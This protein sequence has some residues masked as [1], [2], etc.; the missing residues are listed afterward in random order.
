[1]NIAR[2]DYSAAT[3]GFLNRALANG[4]LTVGELEAKARAAGLLGERQSI[5]HVKAF[6]KA[7]KSLGI[8]SVRGGF[9]RGGQ[10]V[11]IMDQLPTPR[12]PRGAGRP[13]SGPAAIDHAEVEDHP[14]D[15]CSSTGAPDVH[16]P[17][18]WIEGVDA[19][20]DGHPPG[21][22]P[23]H[24]WRQFIVDC[25]KFLDGEENWPDRAVK[26][27]WDALALFGC[28]RTRP[29]EH[30]GCAGLLWAI[31]GGL[32]RELHRDW[33]VIE[34]AEDLSRRVYH[35]RRQDAAHVTLPWRSRPP[36]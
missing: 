1:M 35:R 34:R 15:E 11:W 14:A 6:K 30:L 31:N 21:D 24:R 17:D 2:T 27:G 26:L 29:L 33:A 10:W 5:Q 32:L 9:G 23:L 13:T 19:L 36:A 4:P 25:H 18:S 16:S 12:T 3:T 7:K 22:V 8:K 28:R 20:D